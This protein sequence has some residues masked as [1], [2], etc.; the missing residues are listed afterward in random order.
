[1][2]SCE[3]QLVIETGAKPLRGH[4]SSCPHIKF[5][6][7]LGHAGEIE[8][9]AWLRTKYQVH[10]IADHRSEEAAEMIGRQQAN[11]HPAD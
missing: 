11:A 1:M 8:Q 4:C 6:P 9:L 5:G 7:M 3:S 10:L 2:G